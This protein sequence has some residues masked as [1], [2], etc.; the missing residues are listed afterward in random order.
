[1]VKGKN[2]NY[3]SRK[4]N[5]KMKFYRAIKNYHYTKITFVTKIDYTGNSIKIAISSQTYVPISDGLAA[6]PDWKAFASIFNSFKCKGMKLTVSPHVTS[7]PFLGGSPVIGVLTNFDQNTFGD[8]SESNKSMIMPYTEP[9]TLYVSFNG[10]STGWIGVERYSDLPGKI[11]C[12]I[13]ELSASG[14]FTWD[15]MV[16]YYIMYKTEL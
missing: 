16:D 8:V 10:S 14:I 3:I 15:L 9:K 13:S 11:V 12:A 1:M 5:Y 2:N 4:R 7:Q 6:C